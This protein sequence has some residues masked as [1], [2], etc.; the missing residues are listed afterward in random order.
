VFDKYKNK[1]ILILGL[2]VEGKSTYR[3]I[4]KEYPNK[5]IGIADKVEYANLDDEIKSELESDNLLNLYFGVDYL[6]CVK[7][8][9][10]IFK[11]PGLPVR[12]KQLKEA[13]DLGIEITSQVK[14]F[15]ELIDKNRVIGVTG[16]KGKSTTA[17]LI[18]EMLKRAGKKAFLVGNIGNPLLEALNEFD[19]E[20]LF[21]YE[22]SSYQLEDLNISPHIAVFLNLYEDHLDYHGSK[23]VY[24]YA[25]E[26][27]FRYQNKKDHLII[28]DVFCFLEGDAIEST[29]YLFSLNNEVAQN[30]A[31]LKKNIIYSIL[32]GIVEKVIRIE[33]ISLKGMFNVGNAMAAI[34]AAKIL[35]VDNK[36]IVLALKEFKSLPHRIEYV[37]TINGVSFYDDS[38][39]TIPQATLG[40]IEALGGKVETLIMGGY[41]RNINFDILAEGI[42]GSGV[43]NII[44][45]PGSGIR[46]WD[47]ISKG[48]DFI[49]HFFVSSMKEAVDIAIQKTSAGKVCLLSPASPSFGIYKDYK[50]RGNSFKSEVISHLK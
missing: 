15:F 34:I 4:R 25:K 23:E 21:V 40:A 12:I 2:G 33:D 30:G 18:Y 22:M 5:L 20:S 36:S 1:K 48:N 29:V 49:N 42:A 19:K 14:L 37:Q 9:E 3:L 32:D 39:S 35:G 41:D 6:D 13:S 26:N 27:I 24:R 46:I 45:F 7:D 50:A 10:V 11:S 17:T 8:Y 47:A 31:F 44:L 38:I 43:K 16:T 28:P